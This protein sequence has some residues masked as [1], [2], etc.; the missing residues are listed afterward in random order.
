MKFNKPTVMY[1][2]EYDRLFI[3]QQDDLIKYV[4]PWLLMRDKPSVA[5][6]T[7]GWEPMIDAGELMKDS[8]KVGYL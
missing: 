1:S 8:I 5:L 6:I 7:G 3:A 4:F 2:P